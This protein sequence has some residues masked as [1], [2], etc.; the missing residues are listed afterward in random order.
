MRGSILGSVVGA[1]VLALSLS[2]VTEQ[3]PPQCPVAH[4]PFAARYTLKPGQTATG[5]CTTLEGG[6]VGMVKYSRSGGS[7]DPTVA[8]RTDELG[9]TEPAGTQIPSLSSIGTI[10]GPNDDGQCTI[11][12][13]ST[14]TATVDATSVSYNF[15]N[16]RLLSTGAAPGTH[17]ASEVTYAVDACSAEYDV[18]GI[19]PA[20][21]CDDGT[22]APDETLCSTVPYPDQ[23]IAASGIN[24]DFA[25]T[26][27]PVTLYCQAAK[28]FPSLVQ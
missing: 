17:F 28:P 18:V 13:T 10:S 19:W 25:V 14:A 11:A 9:N 27:D 2:C 12:T 15:H 7:G 21:S 16:M 26:C 1:G 24:P 20:V 23:G 4:G 6:L 3:T 22:G 5:P 8:I